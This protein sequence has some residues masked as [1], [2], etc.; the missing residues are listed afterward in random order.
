MEDPLLSKLIGIVNRDVF[1][2]LATSSTYNLI[3]ISCYA[4]KG[5]NPE[6]I[7]F[8]QFALFRPYQG[9]GRLLHVYFI[10]CFFRCFSYSVLP[11]SNIV[12]GASYIRVWLAIQDT[13]KSY[14]V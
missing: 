14:P 11:P 1:L 13:I 5:D 10:R 12:I 7:K 8:A 4:R 3:I 2:I 9:L 6:Q